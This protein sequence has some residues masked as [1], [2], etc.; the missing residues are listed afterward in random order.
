LLVRYV[1]A[2]LRALRWALDP[3]NRPAVA[4][5]VTASLRVSPALGDRVVA[6]AFAAG[7][8]APDATLDVPGLHGVLALR[9]E[10]CGNWGGLPPPPDGFLEPGPHQEALATL[11][12]P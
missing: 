10:I 4:R 1:R 3:R 12:R 9:A 2:Y 6:P 11:P 8:L 7:G 5:E